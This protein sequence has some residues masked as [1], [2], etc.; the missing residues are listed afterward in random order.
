MADYFKGDQTL[1]QRIMEYVHHSRKTNGG[2]V[3]DEDGRGAVALKGAA[4]IMRQLNAM[5]EQQAKDAD[6]DDDDRFDYFN[7]TQGKRNMSR[8]SGGLEWYRFV[9]R[10]LGNGGAFGGDDVGVVTR[11]QWPNNSVEL[12]PEQLTAVRDALADGQAREN[13]QAALY[14]GK[15]VAAALGIEVPA[16]KRYVARWLADGALKTIQAA[17]HKREQ[18][19]FVR[20]D[21]WSKAVA[22]LG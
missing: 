9:S 4:R 14:V 22:A 1:A 7:V 19:L 5:T 15:I 18:R 21:D 20:L 6:V 16:A 12:T 3:T 11:W 17:D 10:L 8:R 2:Q 13:S